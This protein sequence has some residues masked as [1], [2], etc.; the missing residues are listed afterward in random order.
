MPKLNPRMMQQA[1]RQMGIQQQ[2]LDAVEV[3]IRLPD[4]DLVITE[5]QVAKVSMMGQES[6]QVSGKV[7]ER[8]RSAAADIGEEDIK[9]VMEQTGVDAKTA[10]DALEKAKGDIAEA[11]LSLK[12]E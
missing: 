6:F 8:R 3:V 9:T 4:K 1:M 11:I 7:I 10:K 12:G 2:E 5:P